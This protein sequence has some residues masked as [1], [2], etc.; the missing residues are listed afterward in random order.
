MKESGW[1]T[2]SIEQAHKFD[3]EFPGKIRD[4]LVKES[5]LQIINDIEEN[6]ASP[7][8]FSLIC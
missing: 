7:K 8:K 6:N 1:L 5:F 4:K 3:L 2:R